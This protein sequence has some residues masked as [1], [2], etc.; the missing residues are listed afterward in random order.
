MLLTTLHAALCFC[1]SIIRHRQIAEEHGLSPLVGRRGTDRK[2]R[3]SQQANDAINDKRGIRSCSRACI[4]ERSADKRDACKAAPQ[5]GKD[6]RL[7]FR[8]ICIITFQLLPD[9]TVRKASAHLQKRK[10]IDPLTIVLQQPATVIEIDRQQTGIGLNYR[11]SDRH[12]PVLRNIA[13]PD[14]R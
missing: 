10:A 13:R 11:R 9:A 14:P 1:I 6:K 7:F 8:G 3:N 12:F 5:S 4:T 2:H